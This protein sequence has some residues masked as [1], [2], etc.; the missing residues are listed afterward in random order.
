[1]GKVRRLPDDVENDL[2]KF[3][4]DIVRAIRKVLHIA[5]ENSDYDFLSDEIA[6]KVTERLRVI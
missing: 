5:T 1:M 2:L 6:R 3:D 4:T